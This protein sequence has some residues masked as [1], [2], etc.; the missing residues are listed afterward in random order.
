MLYKN[1]LYIKMSNDYNGFFGCCFKRVVNGCFCGCS[2]RVG[3]IL[4]GIFMFIYDSA[5]IS[6]FALFQGLNHPSLPAGLAL[7]SLKTVVSLLVLI[8]AV[9]QNVG[10]TKASYI[11]LCISNAF[12]S[13]IILAAIVIS[14]VIL[15]SSLNPHNNDVTIAIGVLF[16]LSFMW[17][18]QTI[19]F[20]YLNYV[21][22]S[23]YVSLSKGATEF[24]N[25]VNDSSLNTTK[26]IPLTKFRK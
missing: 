17:V 13:F 10:L 8:S 14:F 16:V 25:G 19:V 2:L 11:L 5:W 12:F 9:G 21:F 20:F 18:C 15:T 26:E 1:L 7:F 23:F 6:Y 22:Y 3:A 4:T 24:L